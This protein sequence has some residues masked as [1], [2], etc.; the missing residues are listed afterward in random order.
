M[1]TTV[2]TAVPSA[3]RRLLRDLADITASPIDK[4]VSACPLDEDIYEWHVN[5]RN[6][7][8][9]ELIL[10]LVM[11]FPKSYPRDPPSVTLCTAVPHANVVRSLS[12]YRICLD[13]L[14]TGKVKAYEGW[15]SS[16]GVASLLMQLQGKLKL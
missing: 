3:T 6:S 2:A 11:K 1:A 16:Y 10:H 12:G 15:S 4:H 8:V 9:A 13:M 7:D 5:L 14:E